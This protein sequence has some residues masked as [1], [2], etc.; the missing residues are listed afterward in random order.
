MQKNRQCEKSSN[1]LKKSSKTLG[2]TCARVPLH[3]NSERESEPC[4]PKRAKVQRGSKTN[5][6]SLQAKRQSYGHAERTNNQ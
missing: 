2:I 4:P 3:Q 6:R 1:M 5:N